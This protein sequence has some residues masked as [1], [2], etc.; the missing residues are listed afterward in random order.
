[1]Y[2]LQQP[3]QVPNQNFYG[4]KNSPD[5]NYVKVISPSGAYWLLTDMSSARGTLYLK[6]PAQ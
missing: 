4:H 5:I 1:V 2:T 3:G 6:A